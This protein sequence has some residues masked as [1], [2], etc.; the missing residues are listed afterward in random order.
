MV[1]GPARF[2]QGFEE[3]HR[4]RLGVLGAN[5]DETSDVVD[6]W[7]FDMVVGEDG[8]AYGF[9]YRMR[10]KN[11]ATGASACDVF[12]DFYNSKRGLWEQ[13]VVLMEGVPLPPD[14]DATGGRQMSVSEWGR[15]VYVFLEDRE[16]VA[17]TTN[18]DSPWAAVAQTNTGPGKRPTLLSPDKAGALG[19]LTALDDAGRAGNGQVVLLDYLP[20][21]TG[22][23]PWS[24]GVSGSGLPAPQSAE[25]LNKLLPGDYTFAYVLH[26]ST[27]GRRSAI[28][29]LAQS[30]TTDFD[31]DGTGV[32]DPVGLYAAIEICYDTTLYDQAYIYRSVRVQGAGGTYIGTIYHLDR[33]IDLADYQTVNNPLADPDQAQAI[34]WYELEDKQLAAQD[35]FEDRTT[36]DENMPQ[37]GAS[38]WY[39]N[40]MLVS[41]IRTA[42]SSS[43]EEIRREDAVRG[44]GEL[45]WSSLTDLS[46]ELFPPANRY[47]P[48]IPTNAIVAMRKVS[49]NVIGFSRD[50]QY[51]IRKES[52]YLKVQE[53]HEGFGVVGNRAV[54]TV[55]SLLYFVSTKGVKAVAANGQ[56][57]DV[58][59]LNQVIMEDWKNSLEKVSVAL[60]PAFSAF[61]IHNE[62][63]EEMCVVWF[64]T[65]TVT[66]VRDVP[67][68][69][70][71][72]GR[73]PE[74]FTF[75]S[76]NLLQDAGVGNSTYANPLVERA[77]FVQNSPKESASDVVSGWSPRIYRVDYRKARMQTTGAG[78]GSHDYGLLPNT[79]DSLVVVGDAYTAPDGQILT[80]NNATYTLP[81][82]CW[83][84][85]IYVLKSSTVD[86]QTSAVIHS[87]PSATTLK[88]TADTMSSLYGLAAGDVL[89]ISP[90]YFEWQGYPLGPVA[91]EGSPMGDDQDFFRV[92]VLDSIGCSFSLVTG[93]LLT[94]DTTLAR[95][96]GAAYLGDRPTPEAYATPVGS[97]GAAV[98]TIK[99][100]EGKYHAA[101]GVNTAGGYAGKH[102]VH[103]AIITPAIIIACPDLD[104]A[105]LGV[106]VRGH[107]RDSVRT[108]RM[109]P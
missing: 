12:A 7:P 29:D 61:F 77:F 10:R 6:L 81:T 39:E 86:I 20:E 3:V 49:P 26:N 87:R 90:I 27:N 72:R 95:F 18:R 51:H 66:M 59:A 46:P 28:S 30:R 96:R 75:D 4:I 94:A 17:L 21:E 102:G 85:K 36:F 106:H 8:Y 82:D 63:E 57:D 97:N 88:L 62:E 91:E 100:H 34:Y 14:L 13:G 54:E 60:D 40:T 52:T 2:F 35:T 32:L 68:R 22:L 53:I 1:E 80:V 79:A 23:F 41:S 89:G 9:V 109:S 44:A 48:D 38:L 19:S 92:K 78:A 73:W 70:V 104:G 98:Q 31:P 42:S 99:D 37:G 64:T 101:F 15:F 58:A 93:Y 11:G 107:V 56:L 71:V 76:D 83:G 55:G 33:V 50:R 74:T 105:L 45:R 25:D 67:F 16:P 5:H 108:E 47:Y 103:G 24:G 43:S 65:G 69:Q 84:Y